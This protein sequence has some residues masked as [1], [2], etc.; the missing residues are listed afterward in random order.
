M[1]DEMLQIE[2]GKR[3]AECRRERQFTQEELAY[4]VGITPQTLSQ[5]ERGRRYPDVTILRSLCGILDISA[6]YLLGIERRKI[7][8]DDNSRIQDE[9][10]RNL[11]TSLDTLKIVM[12]NNQNGNHSLRAGDSGQKAL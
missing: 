5:Y 1:N 7:T 12:G 11:R 9:I 2:F 8:E 10:W 6:D 3:I 4:R